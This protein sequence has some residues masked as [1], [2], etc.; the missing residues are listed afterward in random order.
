LD[1]SINLVI[2]EVEQNIV[3]E[4]SRVPVTIGHL[5]LYKLSTMVNDQMVRDINTEKRNLEQEKQEGV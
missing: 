2:T 4:L 1:K 5:L 3:K